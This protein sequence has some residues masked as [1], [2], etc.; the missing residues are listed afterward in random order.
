[1]RSRPPPCSA[2]TWPARPQ[3]GQPNPSRTCASRSSAPSAS[4][5]RPRAR[6]RH[7][8]HALAHGRRDPCA[9][10]GASQPA[11]DEV[12]RRLPRRAA[13]SVE[14]R[15]R[16]PICAGMSKGRVVIGMSGGVDSSVAAWL[17]KQQGHDVVGLFMKNWEDDDDDEYCSTR[18]DLI[19][20]AA[21]ADVIGI[22]LEA[23]NFAAEYK[24]RVFAEFLREYSG[25]PHAE[26]RRPVQCRD[27]VQGV[28]RPRDQAGRRPH[29]HR[30]LR[31][32]P[33][34]RRQVRAA[35]R[36]RSEQGPEL[37]PAPAEP[38][39]ARA[40]AV[41]DRR[42][43]Q[44]PGARDRT[45][46]RLAECRKARLHRHLLHR[47]AAVPRVPQPLPADAAGTDPDE[48]GRVIGEHV[49]LAF[50]TLGQ[51]KGIGIGGL[52]GAAQSPW[53][54]ARKDIERTHCGSC[55]GTIIPG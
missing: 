44:A 46:D 27:Q 16:A 14:S 26:P 25:R 53:F 49:G 24:D 48:D 11:R 36:R 8:A 3:P 39:A 22:E 18:Q 41:P 43:D 9:A 34:A 20:A 6:P 2:S 42:P 35:A 21:A 4:P 50:Y 23:V 7:P 37:L 52:Q 38:G 55:R 54:V 45:R 51:R 47:R 28:S 40:H 17:L 33:R 1:M 12:H 15:L 31:A 29:R 13:L 32:G 30:T 19:D 10:A 5:S